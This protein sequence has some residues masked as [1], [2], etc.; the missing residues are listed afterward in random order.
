[1]SLI[2]GD[3]LTVRGPPSNS[4]TL[5]GNINSSLQI[6]A[7]NINSSNII[8]LSGTVSPTVDYSKVNICP[9]SSTLLFGKDKIELIKEVMT[10]KSE[11]EKLKTLLDQVEKRVSILEFQPPYGPKFLEIQQEEM[12][13]GIVMFDNE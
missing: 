4:L 5:S 3:G 13:A 9:N 12:E 1:M 6:N 11:N 10:L 8:T 2:T 7:G